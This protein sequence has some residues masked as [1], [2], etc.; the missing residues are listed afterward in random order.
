MSTLWRP[1]EILNRIRLKY[2][3]LIPYEYRPSNLFYGFKCWLTRPYTTIKGRYLPH[4]WCDRD[5]V[6]L[7]TAFEIL[8]QFIE[9]ECSPGNVDW[10]SKERPPKI[11]VNGVEKHIR[12]E[13]QELYDWWHL[14]Y[15]KKYVEEQEKIDEKINSYI[16][17]N[18]LSDV[19]KELRNKFFD[20]ACNIEDSIAKEEKEMLMRLVDIYQYMWT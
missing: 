14:I 18:N 9:R 19:E 20:H 2:W 6:L 17:R 3:R 10:Y 12:D 4:T 15:N 11:I 16:Y 5:Q 8:S 7:H 13:M 1:R